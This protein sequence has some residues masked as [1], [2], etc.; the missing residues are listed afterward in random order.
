MPKKWVLTQEGD[1]HNK[2]MLAVQERG[3]EG[4]NYTGMLGGGKEVVRR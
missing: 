1:Q 3:E 4:E 2:L